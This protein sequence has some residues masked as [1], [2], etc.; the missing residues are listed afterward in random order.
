MDMPD[1]KI[2]QELNMSRRTLELA[3]LTIEN[4]PNMASVR[5][6]DRYEAG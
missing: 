2:R 6:A 4:A 5:W 3:I 1:V